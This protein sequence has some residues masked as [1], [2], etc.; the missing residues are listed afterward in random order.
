MSNKIPKG[1]KAIAAIIAAII[2]GGIT[3]LVT[4]FDMFKWNNTRV[5]DILYSSVYVI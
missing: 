1:D 4:L 5:E 3:A 2:A